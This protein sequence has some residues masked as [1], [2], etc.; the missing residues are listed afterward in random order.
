M[1]TK[2]E[3][4]RELM[5]MEKYHNG[6]LL[7]A[8]QYDARFPQQR[9]DRVCLYNYS[10]WLQCAEELGQPFKP[11]RDHPMCKTFKLIATD[12]CPL[13]YIEKWQ[14]DIEA[15][16]FVPFAN[17]KIRQGPHWAKPEE[18]EEEEEEEEEVDE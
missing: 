9:Q 8:Y 3:I 18:A 1:S 13:E 15:K 16:R 11:D 4:K 17:I 14:E 10:K 12:A 6:E 7:Q 2:E 5:L